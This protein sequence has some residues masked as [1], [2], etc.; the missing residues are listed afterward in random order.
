MPAAPRT[1]LIT[2]SSL[3]V[4]A[5]LWIALDAWLWGAP[6]AVV[7]LLALTRETPYRSKRY[8]ALAVPLL[9]LALT[10]I[11]T[12][13]SP[14]GFAL[15]GA[16]FT[17]ALLL[18]TLILWRE[19]PRPITFA[20]WPKR[21]RPLDIIYTLL[22]VP[23]AWGAFQL[24]FGVLSPQVPFNW[25]LPPAPDNAELV[26]LFIGINLVG[27]WDEL[28]FISVGYAVLRQ[29]FGPRTANLAQAVIYT[30]VL[31]TMAFRGVGPIFVY[32]FALTQGVMFERSKVLLWVL[33]AHLIVDYFLFQAVVTA[34]YP[35]FS[36]WW[37]P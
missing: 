36:V 21:P 11:S 28:F 4:T 14:R 10:P 31:W 16:S 30:T 34:Y 23:L 6:F 26:R 19:R 18:P 32:L 7:F 8:L 2:L 1:T 29:L 33:V 12:D 27:V 13:T 25:E 35:D 37:H 17:L 9:L 3:L 5:A 22:A 20:F 15:L 24:Y